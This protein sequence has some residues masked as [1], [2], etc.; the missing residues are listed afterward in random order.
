MLLI[1][2]TID[3]RVSKDKLAEVL[4][5]EFEHSGDSR[6]DPGSFIEE[7]AREKMWPH[8]IRTQEARTILFAQLYAECINNKAK[9]I[10]K[11]QKT[12]NKK[13]PEDIQQ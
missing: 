3:S 13:K 1:H 9:E 10:I 4:V 8:D 2:I 12:K 7:V 5:H 6:P 11:Q